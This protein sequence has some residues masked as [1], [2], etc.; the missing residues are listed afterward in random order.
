M[1]SSIQLLCPNPSPLKI[2]ESFCHSV[3]G[4]FTYRSWPPKRD[5]EVACH[6]QRLR[7]AAPF[8]TTWWIALSRLGLCYDHA[9]FRNPFWIRLL[10]SPP[11]RYTGNHRQRFKQQKKRSTVNKPT[12][13]KNHTV[14]PPEAV[15]GLM[16]CLTAWKAGLAKQA[17]RHSPCKK[18][19]SFN[20]RR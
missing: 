3:R 13:K 15:K 2:S 6:L 1:I 18:L 17:L 19:E 16:T 4:W 14:L 8:S 9:V 12:T 11:G 7:S 5:I 10:L 20:K